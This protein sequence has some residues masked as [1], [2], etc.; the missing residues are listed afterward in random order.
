MHRLR[1]DAHDL[2]PAHIRQQDGKPT[3]TATPRAR[4]LG[5]IRRIKA[6]GLLVS[7]ESPSVFKKS[8]RTPDWDRGGL[9]KS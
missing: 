8:W 5:R 4:T 9:A 1:H 2:A 3:G 7:R 6:G